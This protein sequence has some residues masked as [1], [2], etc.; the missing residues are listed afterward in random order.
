M[1]AF[2]RETLRQLGVPAVIATVLVA[3]GIAGLAI[4]DQ[5]VKR[6]EVDL[7]RTKAEKFNLRNRLARATDEEREIREKLVDYQRLR[8]QGIVGDENRLDW[9]DT[10]KAI[11]S[12]R[13]LYDL[14]YRI[15]ARRPIDYPGWKAG[16]D[17]EFMMSR[18]RLEAMLAHEIDLVNLLGDLSTRLAPHVSI[19][20]CRID[21]LEQGKPITAPGPK[22][23]SDCVLD[24]I[25][26]RDRA[27][28]TA[29]AKG[30]SPR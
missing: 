7:E 25:T 14:R 6:A 26:V 5:F 29:A 15:D 2:P 3:A 21:R 18:M 4:A 17:V 27:P 12:E 24:L 8:E 11:K 13:K 16:G 22:L 1:I 20:S 23:R 28:G 30:G 10:I 9:I 19:R